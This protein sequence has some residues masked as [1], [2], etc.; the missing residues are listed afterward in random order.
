[1][2]FSGIGGRGKRDCRYRAHRHRK[3]DRGRRI[4]STTSPG[5][6]LPHCQCCVLLREIW[7]E[8]IQLSEL[9]SKAGCR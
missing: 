1:M 7:T 4:L 6:F 3:M 9:R 8:E 2:K 5:A